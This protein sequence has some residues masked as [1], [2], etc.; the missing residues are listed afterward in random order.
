M[1]CGVIHAHVILLGCLARRR[2][3]SWQLPYAWKWSRDA[4]GWW[5]PICKGCRWR[6][7]RDTRKEI[8][9][10]PEWDELTYSD[11]WQVQWEVFNEGVREVMALVQSPRSGNKPPGQDLPCSVVDPHRQDLE[12]AASKPIPDP[13]DMALD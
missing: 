1:K 9:A 13:D 11:R 4:D 5:R 6:I 12:Q 2:K 8:E 10:S 3:G 7:W